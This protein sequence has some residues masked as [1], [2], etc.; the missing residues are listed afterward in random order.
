ME[1]SAYLF[2]NSKVVLDVESRHHRQSLYNARILRES[3]LLETTIDEKVFE[4]LEIVQTADHHRV[5]LQKSLVRITLQDFERWMLR[6]ALS[7]L[8]FQSLNRT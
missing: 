8:L 7:T 2:G 4:R 1:R 3:D 6:G 5:G